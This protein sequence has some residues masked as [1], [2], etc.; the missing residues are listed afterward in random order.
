MNDKHTIYKAESSYTKLS[1]MGVS[2][3]KE[4]E[5]KLSSPSFYMS[6]SFFKYFTFNGEERSSFLSHSYRKS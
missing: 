4:F 6:V 2:M 1:D 5:D 3:D